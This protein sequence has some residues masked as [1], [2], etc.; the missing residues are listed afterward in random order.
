LSAAVFGAGLFGFSSAASAQETPAT[1]P[2]AAGAQ[3]G[4][5]AATAPVASSAPATVI[6]ADTKLTTLADDFMHYTLVNN[7]ELAKA[8]GEAILNNP[9][10]P[11]EVLAAFEASANGRVPRDIIMQAVRRQD[12]H[13]VGT[14]LLDRL[15]EGYRKVAR[16]PE[17]IR[18]EVDRLNSGPRA[19]QNAKD[20]LTAAGQF[21]VPI[22]IEYLQNPAKKELQPDIIRVMSEIGR[23]LLLPLIEALR[24]NDNSIRIQLVNVIGQI[25]Y[26]QA[27]PALRALQTDQNTAGEL[28]NA[29][30]NAIRRINIPA[31]ANLSPA[32]LSLYAAENYYQK[33][34]SYQPLLPDEK[35][36]PVWVFDSGLNNVVALNVPT[37]IWNSVMA[38]RLAEQ[39]LKADSNNGKAISLWLAS[40]LR[41]EIQLPQGETDP[42][43]KAGEDASFYARAAGPIYVNPVLAR[44]L[45]ENDAALALQAIDALEATGGSNGLVSGGEN[46]PLV[47]AL[48][49]PDRSVR[50]RA[51][52]ALAGA[53]PAS[54]YPGFYRVV[55]ILAEAVGSTG[56]P[57][58]IVVGPEDLRN[59]ITATLRDGATHY[60]VFA[61]G[62]LTE[63]VAQAHRAPAVDLV[64][65][66]NDRET[67]NAVAQTA[68]TDYHLAGVPVLVAA[69][70][71]ALSN[72]KL[73]L[74][75]AKGYGAVDVA[76][77]DAAIT[78]AVNAARADIGSVPVN[79]EKAA[80]YSA[81]AIDLL[82]RLAADHHS[83]Y[84]VTEAVPTLSDALHDKRSEIATGAARDLGQLNS[85]DAQRALATIAL[86]GDTDPAMRVIFLDALAESAK[87]TGL[88]IDAPMISSLIKLVSSD[89][90]AKVK[91]AAATALGALNVP[92]NQ[93]STLILQQSK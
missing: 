65:V 69:P 19:Y 6:P 84:P 3:G 87:R 12:L 92:S 34:P 50:F 41:R 27:L 24:T 53:N 64:V 60:T 75:N 28:K 91:T 55:P 67:L 29:V 40:D 30:D 7:V 46:A 58:A 2:G 45:D 81:T 39:T 17:R 85:A 10:S 90:D 4:A 23:P 76:A 77:D 63:A 11:E 89:S 35:T 56:S 32:D 14:K 59:K 79:A 66:P 83:I 49:H 8:N 21:A 42:T 44:A 1:A 33:K 74:A 43:K 47:R 78:S 15:E 71:D 52:F 73:Q 82:G 38:L 9:A 72:L 37:P 26:P 16:D 86:A 80:Q 48:S 20:R 5:A 70:A 31:A 54:Q 13:D 61:A 62:T 68:R 93:A 51:A 18:K 36:N 88:A 57:T 22:Y 25:G